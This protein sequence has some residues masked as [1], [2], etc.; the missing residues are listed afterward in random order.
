MALFVTGMLV[1]LSV[2]I[3][4]VAVSVAIIQLEIS[5]AHMKVTVSATKMRLT[6]F[7]VILQMGVS[8]AIMQVVFFCI[9]GYK[10]S[11]N[12]FSRFLTLSTKLSYAKYTKYGLTAKISYAKL[13]FFKPRNHDF[14]LD[15]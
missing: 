3:K 14:C 15:F 9:R 10:F 7:V 12:L 1:D 2:A 13:K 8:V 5:A 6:N 11:R 4:Q